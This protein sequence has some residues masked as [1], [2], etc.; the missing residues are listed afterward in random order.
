M[1]KITPTWPHFLS[2]QKMS[3]SVMNVYLNKQNF[4][5]KYEILMLKAVETRLNFQNFCYVFLQLS[6]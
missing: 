2:T 5:T 4:A 3:T 1:L 6:T